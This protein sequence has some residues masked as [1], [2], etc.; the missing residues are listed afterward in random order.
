MLRLKSIYAPAGRNDG[1][2]YLIARTWPRN[3]NKG[4]LHLAG[5]CQDIAPSAA[6]SRLFHQQT[7]KWADF[8]HWYMRELELKPEAWEPLSTLAR[9]GC[10]L[11]LLY[12]ERDPRH[13]AAAALK[14]FLENQSASIQ[15]RQTPPQAA[16]P[17]W[18]HAFA[19][20]AWIADRAV[21]PP[22]APIVPPAAA[23]IRGL[24]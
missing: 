15:L 24:Q 4:D 2:R 19:Q 10:T 5:W 21:P 1:W 6:L 16:I 23:G 14:E 17:L 12:R 8:C 3:L 11:T 20:H 9:D 22:P 18:F 13:S 7:A